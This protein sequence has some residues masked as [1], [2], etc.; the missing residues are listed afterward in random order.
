MDLLW[1][2]RGPP[3]AANNLHQAV[4]VARRALGGLRR[5]EATDRPV[6]VDE[7]R[8]RDALDVRA[9]YD[10]SRRPRHSPMKSRARNLAGK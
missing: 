4:Y 5:H 10:P 8:L 3:A 1:R 2:D 6:G 9:L 7:V